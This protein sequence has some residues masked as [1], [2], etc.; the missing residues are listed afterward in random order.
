MY[1]DCN[2]FCCGGEEGDLTPL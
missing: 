1:A 2:V